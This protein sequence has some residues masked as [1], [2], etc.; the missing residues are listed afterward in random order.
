MSGDNYRDTAERR[1]ESLAN[2]I[3]RNESPYLVFRFAS[4]FSNVYMSEGEGSTFLHRRGADQ[5]L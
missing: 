4:S 1:Y 3:R 2:D 5:T